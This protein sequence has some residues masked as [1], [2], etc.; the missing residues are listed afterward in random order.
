MDEI[1]VTAAMLQAG[2]AEVSRLSVDSDIAMPDYFVPAIYRAMA[3][4]A[5]GSQP[6]DADLRH[7]ATLVSHAIIP[8]DQDRSSRRD[9]TDRLLAFAAEIEHRARKAK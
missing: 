8:D 5:P 3:A 4:A 7:A 6:P 9:I 1:E 2:K